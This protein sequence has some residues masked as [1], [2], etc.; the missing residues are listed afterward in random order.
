MN[1]IDTFDIS[2]KR[3]LLVGGTGVLGRVYAKALASRGSLL[4]IGDRPGSDV[5][6][7]ASQLPGNVKGVEVDV[8]DESSV[9]QGVK[10]AVEFLGGLDAVINNAAL[11]GESLLA[12]RD[13]FAP[14][15]EYP[16]SAF[17]AVLDVN[18]TGTFLVAREAGRVMKKAGSGSLINVSSIYGIVGPDHRIYEGQSFK[19]M[20]GYSASKAGVIGL[21]R[22]LATWW[23]QDGIR[24]N[25]VVPG[26]VYNNHSES[27]VRAY[28][29]RT[30][31]GRMADREELTGIII[32]LV[33]DASSYCTG[34]SFIIDGGFTAW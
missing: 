10:E 12:Q 23:G 6:H 22:W 11:T 25:C 33:A 19:S 13:V 16:L 28:G 21:T 20:P 9:C 32:Y 17:R 7:M 26:G 3:V 15:E 18:L 5:L 8:T 31:L 2:Q 34:Q 29:S 27:F 14:F 24:V 30:P 4:V 1:K